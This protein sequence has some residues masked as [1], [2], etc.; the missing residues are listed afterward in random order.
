MKKALILF[1]LLPLLFLACEKKADDDAA[2]QDGVYKGEYANF[3]GHGWKPQLEITVEDGDIT[4]ANWDYVNPQG[5]LKSQN[6]QYASIMQNVSGTTPA[7]AKEELEKML[8]DG[9]SADVDVVTGATHSSEF[10]EELAGAILAQAATGDKSLVSLPMNGTYSAEDEFGSHGWKAT[11]SVT[12]EDEKIV[13][14]DFQEVD[15][16]GAIKSESEEYATNM[17]PVSGTTPAKAEEELEAQ[18]L[19]AQSAD[20]DG[21]TG[22]TG[23]STRFIALVKDILSQ[24]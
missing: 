12:F 18:L 15:E 24:R 22:A 16:E 6:E 21:V 14:V 19:A 9:Q 10:F 7:K 5:D 3:D 17:E 20:I 1:I 2:F 11:L 8:L 13:A 4:Q 23:S